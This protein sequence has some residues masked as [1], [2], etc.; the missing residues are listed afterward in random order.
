MLGAFY[1]HPWHM[2]DEKGVNFYAFP[3]D[4]G[5][6]ESAETTCA[7]VGSEEPLLMVEHPAAPADGRY[8]HARIS[9]GGIC[10]SLAEA[11]EPN[12][13]VFRGCLWMSV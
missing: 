4:T 5:G 9:V 3:E 8:M 13:D 7:V 2:G 12:Q 10:V 1:I 11:L 6:D